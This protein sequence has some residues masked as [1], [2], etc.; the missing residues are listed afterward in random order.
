MVLAITL[1]FRSGRYS[2]NLVIVVLYALIM[3]EA[4]YESRIILVVCVFASK[5]THFHKPPTFQNQ[6][7]QISLFL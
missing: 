4:L 3:Q 2:M 1:F 6:D 5:E 7:L